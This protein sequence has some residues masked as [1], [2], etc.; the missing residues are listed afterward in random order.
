MKK[1]MKTTADFLDDL[2]IKYELP[3]DYAIAKR[4]N[5]HRQQVSKY[6]TCKFTF[7]DETAI[8]IA[9]E[10]GVNEAYVMACM[11]AQRAKEE[12]V[13]KAWEKAAKLLGGVAAGVAIMTSPVLGIDLEAAPLLALTTASESTLYIMLNWLW[14]TEPNSN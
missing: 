5:M 6:R 13:K 10:L 2:K 1:T 9:H 4:L 7:D 8:K 3:S 11:N 14:M 12:N